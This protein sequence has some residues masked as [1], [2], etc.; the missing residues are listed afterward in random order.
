MHGRK[1]RLS[2]DHHHSSGKV[3]GV[4]CRKCNAAIGFLNEDA[5]LLEKAASYVRHWNQPAIVQ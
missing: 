2:V 1:T 4:L 3:R 5:A